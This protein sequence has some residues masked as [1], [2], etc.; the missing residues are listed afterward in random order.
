MGSESA[1]VTSR[2]RALELVFMPTRV[3]GFGLSLKGESS[4]S[5]HFYEQCSQVY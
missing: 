2:V 4:E 1:G 3:V 5:L